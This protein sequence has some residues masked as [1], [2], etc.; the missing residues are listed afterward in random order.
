[1]AADAAEGTKPDK[2]GRPRTT[3]TTINGEGL[4]CWLRQWRHTN[5]WTQERL[6]E[7]LGYEVSYVAKIERGRRRPTEQF[8]SRLAEV[9]ATPRQQL[10]QLCRRPTARLRLAVPTETAVGRTKEIDEVS[11]LLLRASCTTLVGAPGVGK[12]TL[13]VEVAWNVAENYRDGVCFVPLTEASDRSDVAAAIVEHL[14]LA[15]RGG[16]SHEDLIIESLRH[17]RMLL[18]LDNFEH[19]LEA[20]PLVEELILQARQVRV[21]TTS[22]EALGVA[23]EREYAVLPLAFPDPSGDLGGAADYPAV[24]AF[25]SRSRLVRP[26]FALT[27]INL[28]AV[29]DICARLDGLPLAISLTAAATRLISPT[30]IARSLGPRLELATE[31]A[32]S[33]MVDR[34]LRASM[35]WSWELLHPGQQALLARLG[36]FAAG[37]SLA[38]VEAICVGDGDGADL[39]DHL[40]ALENKSLVHPLPSQTGISR[41]SSL[42]TI[43]SYAEGQLRASG[44]LEELRQRHCAYYTALVEDVEPHLTGGQNQSHWLR[45][46]EEDHANVAAAFHWTLLRQPTDAVRI[47]AALWRYFSMRRVSEGRRWLVAALQCAPVGTLPYL[48]ALIGSCVLARSQGE[49]E[50]AD[51]GLEEARELA[52]TLGARSELALAILNQGIV[53]EQ[54]GRYDVAKRHFEVATA[55]YQA[56]G[57]ERGVGHGLNCLGVIALRRNDKEAASDRFLQAI[58]RFRALNDRWSVAVTATNL[59]WMAEVEGEL[60]DARDWYE[61]SRQIR[62]GIGDEYA[63]ARSTADLGRIA[64]RQKDSVVAAKLLNQALHVFQRTGDRRLAAACLVE[65]GAVAAQQRRRE[66]AARLLGAAESVRESLGMPAWPEEQALH[67]G[68]LES[69]GATNEGSARKALRTG[70]A[71][72]LEDAVELVDSGTWPPAYQ[73]WRATY[74]VARELPV[75]AGS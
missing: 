1:V 3:V 52:A 71:L 61:E 40:A 59:G 7:A 22:R 41:F 35:N 54:R 53:A 2:T 51:I 70:R 49:V 5:R 55:L 63:F 15:E 31:G 62:E 30:D 12:T 72:T 14:G 68:V 60:A 38:A 65:L 67:D 8:V 25:V 16:R 66:M 37:Y 43:K 17:R 45:V 75:V 21:L 73:R 9:T 10:L 24:Q 42:E 26:D 20:R 36:V 4:A 56:I 48:R 29:V 6:A 64:R 46:L 23:G 34:R 32:P 33:A 39:L 18:V 28:R 57:E 27:E 47:A 19:V 58:S 44:R 74:S 50:V 69:I 13:A 11:A